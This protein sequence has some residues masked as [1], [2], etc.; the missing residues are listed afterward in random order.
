MSDGLAAQLLDAARAPDITQNAFVQG[1]A[2]G[3]HPKTALRDYARELAA[4]AG[5]LPS[6]L[7]RL[8]SHCDDD[9]ARRVL[10]ENLLEETGVAS[11]DSSAGLVIAPHRIHVGMAARFLRATGAD[12]TDM[13]SRASGEWLTGELDR[14]R[15]LGPFAYVCVG[16]EANVPRAFRLLFAGLRAHYGFSDEDL[17]FFTEHFIA[18]E[19]HGALGAGVAAAAAGTDALRQE[20]FRGARRGALAFWHLHQRHARRARSAGAA[21]G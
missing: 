9:R 17:E 10:L 6:V 5:N 13:T 7:A 4:L 11:Y 12:A 8:Y 18:D 2:E 20:A 16:I 15:W 19:K 21:S 3:R 1:I 14:G